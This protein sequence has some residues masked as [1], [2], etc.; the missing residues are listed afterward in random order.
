MASES[1]GLYEIGIEIN[2]C[3]GVNVIENKDPV[4]IFILDQFLVSL[5]SVGIVPVM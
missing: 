4:S 3:L 1:F 2:H 5:C